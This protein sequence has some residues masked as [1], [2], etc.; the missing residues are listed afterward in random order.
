MLYRKKVKHPA[1]VT[2]THSV[3][4]MCTHN[5]K[6]TLFKTQYNWTPRNQVSLIGELSTPGGFIRH[7]PKRR[8]QRGRPKQDRRRGPHRDQIV[9]T[10]VYSGQARGQQRRR[11]PGLSVW[12]APHVENTGARRHKQGRIK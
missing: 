10:P 1:P 5:H 7:S 4:R 2:Y 3:I 11:Q 8:Y 6:H 12:R 9:L